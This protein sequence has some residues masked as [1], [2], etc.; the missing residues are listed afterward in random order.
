MALVPFV[1]SA[2]DEPIWNKYLWQKYLESGEISKW[3]SSR[4]LLVE[5][6]FYRRIKQIFESS[7]A[8]KLYDPFRVQKEHLLESKLADLK[9]LADYT[10]QILENLPKEKILRVWSHFSKF[11][12]ITLWGNHYDLSRPVQGT[13]EDVKILQNL[14]E[15]DSHILI[16]DSEEIW[17]TLHANES[18]NTIDFVN[19]NAGYELFCDLCLADFL[20]TSLLAKKIQFHVKLMPWFISDATVDDFNWLLHVIA[21]NSQVVPSFSVLSV[22]WK[23]YLDSG[24]WILKNEKF[25]TLPIAYNEMKSWDTKLYEDLSNSTLILFKGDVNYR[26]LLADKNWPTTEYFKSVLQSFHPTN[27]AV[28]RTVKC[29]IICGMKSEEA[30]NL[31]AREP[32]W[33]L[34]GNYAVIQFDRHEIVKNETKF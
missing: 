17:K 15:L 16:D 13:V 20:C 9:I 21:Q 12:K 23:N 19:D 33:M 8:F 26:K 6:Y 31:S 25:W 11:L 24:I 5:C 1:S 34:S 27:L 30:E 29:E 7:Y 14:D 22:R 3:L 32:D 28:L 18:N 2:E 10:V 4:W